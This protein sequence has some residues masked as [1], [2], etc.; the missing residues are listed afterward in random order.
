MLWKSTILF[1]IKNYEYI[2][3]FFK[4]N[5]TSKEQNQFLKS[6]YYFHSFKYNF[7]IAQNREKYSNFNILFV[8]KTLL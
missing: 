4:W 8:I 2:L 6:Q 3:I 1:Y 7:V 5:I